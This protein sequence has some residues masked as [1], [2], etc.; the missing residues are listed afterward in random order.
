MSFHLFKVYKDWERDMVVK[1]S[2][3]V[4][5]AE[6]AAQLQVSPFCCRLSYLIG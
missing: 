2:A 4:E 5:M 3:G 1:E 6:I